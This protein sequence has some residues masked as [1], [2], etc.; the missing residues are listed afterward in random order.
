MYTVCGYDK[1]NDVY[2]LYMETDD[3]DAALQLA[4]NLAA[5]VKNDCLCRPCTDG[6]REPIDWIE[7][8]STQDETFIHW[9][10]YNN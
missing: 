5:L 3:W 1:D 8:V 10:S 7:I 4:E 2:T 9:A 6:T